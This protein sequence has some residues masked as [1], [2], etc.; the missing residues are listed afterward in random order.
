M[1]L[2]F[3]SEGACC[4]KLIEKEGHVLVVLNKG[5]LNMTE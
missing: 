4:N 5:Q 1:Y 2:F 3:F